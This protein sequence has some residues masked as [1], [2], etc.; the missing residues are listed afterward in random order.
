MDNY[1][2]TN[3]LKDNK[4]SNMLHKDDPIHCDYFTDET[5]MQRNRRGT[6]YLNILSLNIVSLPKHGNELVC[7]IQSLHMKFDIIVLS[8]IGS[9]NISTVECLLEEYV[10]LCC[11]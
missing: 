6:E 11:T 3:F 7:L 9:R 4:L 1:K 8:E 5:L 2:L 10:S